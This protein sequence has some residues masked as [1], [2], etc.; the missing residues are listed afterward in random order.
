MRGGV[1]RWASAVVRQ[2]CELLGVAEVDSVKSLAAFIG[3]DRAD[4]GPDL[5]IISLRDNKLLSFQ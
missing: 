4:A 2:S 1:S 5:E 3:L